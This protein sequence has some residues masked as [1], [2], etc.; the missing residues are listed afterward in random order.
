[1]KKLMIAA[2]IV[3]A[4]AVVQAA[5]VVNW[6]TGS[7][8]APG[9]DGTGYAPAWGL[10]DPGT[11]GVLATLY[12]AEDAGFENAVTF[13]SGFTGSTVNEEWQITGTTD[14]A[15][16]DG[17]IYYAKM[18]VTY[19]DSILESQIVE[20]AETSTIT[21]STDPTF[22]D[23]GINITAIGDN[24]LDE[25]YG[26]FPASGWQTVPEPTSGLLLLLGVAGL[27]LRRRRA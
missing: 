18:I 22:G 4:A 23:G 24:Q 17:Q 6:S 1:M 19:G 2:A 9:E 13:T 5:S 20:L 14:A 7:L 16:N 11:A 10:I 27:A 25:V 26:A 3:C 8:F 21:F 12:V 15:L